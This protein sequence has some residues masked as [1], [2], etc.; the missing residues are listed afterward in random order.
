MPEIYVV[1][2]AGGCGQRLWPL[3]SKKRPKQFIPFVGQKTLIELALERALLLVKDTKHIVVVTNNLYRELLLQTCG[4]VFGHV[5]YEPVGRNTAPAVLR[6]CLYIDKID[7]E[8]MVIVIPADHFIP[9][10]VQFVSTVN[11]MVSF[12]EQHEV[13]G[14]LGLLPTFPA[15][16]YGYIQRSV[17]TIDQNNPIYAVEK[18]HEKPNLQT[19][20]FYLAAGDMLW[21]I[22]LFIGRGAVIVAEF[23]RHAPTVYAGVHDYLVGAR[24]YADVPNI[25]IDIAVMEKSN[26]VV[27][28]RANFEWY[29]V[30]SLETFV[31]V[32][33]VY[34]DVSSK[35]ISLQGEN[36]IA[37][38]T[39]KVVVCV[40]TNNLCI[41]E[42]NDEIIIFDR[43][44]TNGIKS[45]EFMHNKK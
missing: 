38:T 35:L 29:D 12:T 41:I 28:S 19:A 9:D 22:G 42:T 1:V 21:N 3:S 10:K 25:S 30:G 20:E 6:A 18:F 33:T 40:D 34:G 15:T 39:K 23:R 7:S 8:A 36:N 32:M 4:D 37:Y 43:Q 16:G 5:I 45:L 2:L 24:E 17:Q 44:K 14:L 26:N 13:I 31:S 11:E 27:V